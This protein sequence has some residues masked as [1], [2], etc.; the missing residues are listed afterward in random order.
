MA[1]RL[2]IAV[3]PA[4][5][6]AL[7]IAD[8]AIERHEGHLSRRALG[9]N[10]MCSW[11]QASS[12]IIRDQLYISGG[13]LRRANITDPNSTPRI[14][15]N[16]IPNSVFYLNLG[17]PFNT[18]SV[19]FKTIDA[20]FSQVTDGFMAA[21]DNSFWLY[22][23]LIG[24][25]DS[26]LSYPPANDV[27]VYDAYRQGAVRDWSQGWQI[28]PALS[29]GVSRYVAGGA[30]V[31]VR[32]LNATYYFSGAR[33][34]NWGEIR[35]PGRVFDENR[36][37]VTSSQFISADLSEQVRTT[38]TNTTLPSVARPR[39]DGEMVYVPAGKIGSLIVLGGVTRAEWQVPTSAERSSGAWDAAIT[40]SVN[41]GPSFFERVEV[42]DLSGK[43]WYLQNTTGDIPPT[44][45]SQ[46]CATVATSQ[47][48]NSHQIYVYGGYQGLSKTF[49]VPVYDSVYV[50]SIPAFQWIKISD[51]ELSTARKGH[52]CVKPLPDQ[53]FIIGGAPAGET[54]C[55]DI[56][57]IFNLNTLQFSTEYD[58]SVYEEYKVP[59]RIIDV[60]GGDASGGA[61]KTASRWAAATLETIFATER[62]PSK[63]INW[64]PYASVPAS[65]TPSVNIIQTKSETPKF[66]YPV[67]AV[68]I[69][70]VL[71][72]VGGLIAF[73]IIRRRRQRREAK[74]AGNEQFQ[75]TEKDTKLSAAYQQYPPDPAH[76][77]NSYNSISTVAPAYSQHLHDG[78]PQIY[79]ELPADPKGPAEL[80]SGGEPAKLGV[81]NENGIESLS[82]VPTP[83]TEHPSSSNHLSIGT[84]QSVFS[85]ATTPMDHDVSP[86]T[87]D[88][89][90]AGN[91]GGRHS[92]AS[93]FSWWRRQSSKGSAIARRFSSLSRASITR[94]STGLSRNDSLI[95]PPAAGAPATENLTPPSPL[96]E[97]PVPSNASTDSVPAPAPAPPTNTS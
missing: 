5:S 46:F 67:I 9:N 58:P 94:T 32:E 83:A 80:D 38:W 79:F 8:S 91:P 33:G 24:E 88:P 85:E 28:G 76:G 48:G 90:I 2:L 13:V 59:Q 17:T 35:G 96:S 69:V 97:R 77:Y 62:P 75:N 10:V 30:G 29:S 31:N 60:I 52:K 40:Q 63:A 86:L 19:P 89:E 41:T 87:P 65:S 14:D 74:A 16:T 51:G 1:W 3:L 49:P 15:I 82:I 66:V 47:D 45:I 68:C 21:N 36:A 61:T 25:T 43:Q 12:A 18:S 42:Y 57:R 55:N 20:P 93:E 27:R 71:A 44:G 95:A 70:V 11:E 73:F 72:I 26:I 34:Q 54:Q 4:L 56:V 23:G 39:V 53:M 6:E 78:S 7:V 37:N 64:Y 92:S 50:L 81:I 84:R 22:G